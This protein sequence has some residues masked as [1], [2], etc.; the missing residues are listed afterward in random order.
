MAEFDILDVPMSKPKRRM[1]DYSYTIYGQPKWG[2]SGFASMFPNSLFFG[3]EQGQNALSVRLVPI[4]DWK[5]FKK[6]VLQLVKAKESGKQIPYRNFVFDTADVAWKYCT[7]YVCRQNG[8]SHPSDAEWGK[9]WQ[10]VADE[11]FGELDKLSK[12]GTVEDPCTTIYIAHHE[13]KEF[14]PKNAKP[15]NK[16]VP[17]LPK[18]GRAVIVDKVDFIIYCDME[19]IEVDDAR[20][21]VRRMY[22]RDNGAFEA[23]SRLRYMPDFIEHGDTKEEAFE[24]FS[25]AF[26]QAVIQEFGEEGSTPTK[27]QVDTTATV[28]AEKKDKAEAE[29]K[30]KAEAD[31]KA[32]QKAEEKAKKEEL[33]KA[34]VEAEKKAEA[35][36]VKEDEKADEKPEKDAENESSAEGMSDNLVELKKSVEVKFMELYKSG[37][38]S[39]T[40]LVALVEEHTGFK[41]ISE[42]DDVAKA[43]VLLKALQSM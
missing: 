14:K 1:S 33:A 42:I 9:G 24:N 36:K 29:A 39:P 19:T 23:G 5:E 4:S 35:D 37:A 16:I 40:E 27:P 26:E 28:E 38:K 10:A 20:V 3:F 18:G 25:R 2:K 17:S 7:Q 32:K 11:W 22:I 34:K 15:Y 21:D 30:K 43:Q 13:D 6:Y 31:L 41:K 12:L 8:W